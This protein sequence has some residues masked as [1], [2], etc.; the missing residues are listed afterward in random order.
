[1][2]EKQRFDIVFT[3][4]IAEGF[5]LAD[6]KRKAAQVFKMD[7]GKVDTLFQSK[8]RTLKKNLDES[9]ANKYQ[10]ILSQIGMVV[11]VQPQEFIDAKAELNHSPPSVGT[12]ALPDWTLDEVGALL[13]GPTPETVSHVEAPSYTIATQPCNILTPD[14]RPKIVPSLEIS[15]LEAITIN[16]VGEPLLEM[17]EKTTS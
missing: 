7:D 11:L 8:A 14:E 9:A 13:T 4:N 3:G 15:S 1:M 6:V 16:D 17:S 12:N 5:T 10:K 2:T